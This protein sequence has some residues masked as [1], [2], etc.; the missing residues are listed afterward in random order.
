MAALA[1]AAAPLP[2]PGA[3]VPPPPPPPA[4]EVGLSAADGRLVAIIAP[5]DPSPVSDPSLNPKLGRSNGI[6]GAEV[7][8][9]GSGGAA[10][11]P[12][13]AAAAAAAGAVRLPL[14]LREFDVEGALLRA[15]ASNAALQLGAPAADPALKSIMPLLFC[16]R[17]CHVSIR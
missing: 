13:T 10:G 7:G 12:G 9:E 17:R 15:A 2:E 4:I 11:G 8:K 16:Y 6:A 14:D 1:A 3:P 5:S